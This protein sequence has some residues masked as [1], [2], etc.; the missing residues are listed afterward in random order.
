MDDGDDD[1]LSI[2]KHIE[3]DLI[4]GW[5]GLGQLGS[6]RGLIYYIAFLVNLNLLVIFLG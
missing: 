5:I 4:I 6:G 2:F 3:F 1:D